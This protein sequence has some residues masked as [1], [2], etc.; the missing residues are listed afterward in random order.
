MWLSQICQHLPYNSGSRYIK[1]KRKWTSK[2]LPCEV[3][4]VQTHNESA[5]RMLRKAWS[6]ASALESMAESPEVAT[7]VVE[8]HWQHSPPRL[9]GGGDGGLVDGDGGRDGG[10]GRDVAAASA[11]GCLL[12]TEIV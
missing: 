6:E 11:G 10:G 8:A 4:V 3:D 1:M 12:S 9:G 7:H 2:C 5:L